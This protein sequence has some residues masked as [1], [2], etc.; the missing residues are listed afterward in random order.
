MEESVIL[1]DYLTIEGM[2]YADRREIFEEL[3]DEVVDKLIPL[4][5]EPFVL[6]DGEMMLSPDQV[7]RGLIHLS[8]TL[9]LAETR[10][11]IQNRA[12]V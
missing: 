7:R 2:S 6:I 5:G 8:G 4:I 10:N 12:R 11:K 1:R 3:P 9:V